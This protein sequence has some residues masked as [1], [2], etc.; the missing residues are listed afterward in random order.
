MKQAFIRV[1]VA[2]IITIVFVTFYGEAFAAEPVKPQTQSDVQREKEANDR[3]LD[4]YRGATWAAIKGGGFY[5][6]AFGVF[7]GVVTV[8]F[9]PAGALT[10]ASMVAVVAVDTV[11]FGLIG[12][13]AAANGQMQSSE[14]LQE[15]T[16]VEPTLFTC[17]M[18]E[19]KQNAKEGADKLKEKLQKGW[20][21]GKDAAKK[22]VEELKKSL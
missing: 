10:A 19:A 5:G 4:C 7:S 18:L 8:A 6:A 13:G 12:A 9:A 21:Q 2:L 15:K 1:I 20:E 11:T 14:Y 22:G 16:G 17:S 3:I